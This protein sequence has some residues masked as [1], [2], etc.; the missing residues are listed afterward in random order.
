MAQ[1]LGFLLRRAGVWS[2]APTLGS[3]LM[4]QV[5]CHLLQGLPSASA[6]PL[7]D[8]SQLTPQDL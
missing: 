8:F 5:H 1:G 4:L 7:N 6:R 2:P 3:S